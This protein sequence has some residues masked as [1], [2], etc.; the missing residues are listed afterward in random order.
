MARHFGTKAIHAG[1][2]PDPTTG[3]IMTPVYLTSTYAQEA[4]ARHKGYVY[5]RGDNPT[6]RA[7]ED[8]V[9]ALEGGSAAVCT[10]SGLGATTIVLQDLG[11]DT[12]V[13]A[14]DD[15]YGGTRRLFDRV[16]R[17]L[18]MRFDYVD[19]SD[20]EALAR[21]LDREP[22]ALLWLESPTN[23]LLK[24][25]DLRAGCDLAHRH[26]VPVLVDNTFA[27]PYLQRP[28]DHG[29]DVVLHSMTK[30]LGGH[31]DVV[32]GAL[33]VDD[34]GREERYRFLANAAGPVPGPLDCFLVLRG[35]KTLHVRMERHCDNA[36]VLAGRLRE[37]S[38]VRRAHYPGLEEHPGHA[39]ARRQMDRFGGMISL[40][41]DGGV[42]EA[43]RFAS[44]TRLFELAESLGGVESLIE[45][46]ASMTH[47]SV[48]AEER[49]KSGLPDGLLRLSVGIED[50]E[51]L[52]T[53][54]ESAFAEVFPK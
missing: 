36:E 43:E 30:Y 16:F 40:E 54:L 5:G 33:V 38:R 50:V 42:G 21:A 47:A 19:S 52:W 11:A 10:S 29:A 27:S 35:I 53:D 45:H 17:R 34:P 12:R 4:P 46:P 41:L 39:V 9:A 15:L 7:L 26:G 28:L 44:S 22:T 25:T 8:C 1:Q 32:A 20:L 13:V 23:P 51:D 49:R 48:P 18:G 31:S 2:A 14:G 37:H 3:A 6:R 24:I